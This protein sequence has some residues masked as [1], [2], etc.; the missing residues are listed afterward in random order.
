MM[1]RYREVLFSKANQGSRSVV[2]G[3]RIAATRPDSEKCRLCKAQWKT[4]ELKSERTSEQRS[5]FVGR[6][7]GCLRV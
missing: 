2:H 1:T 4:H 3:R 6:H 7:F 5:C